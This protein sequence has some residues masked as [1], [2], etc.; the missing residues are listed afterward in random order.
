MNASHELTTQEQFDVTDATTHHP[1]RQHSLCENKLNIYIPSK[2]SLYLNSIHQVLNFYFAN[3]Q[4]LKNKKLIVKQNS[5]KS[6]GKSIHIQ[7]NCV[8]LLKNARQFFFYN[9]QL[10]YL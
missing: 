4:L 8:P 6:K 5:I 3:K 1:G 7:N 9:K 2:T 10:N